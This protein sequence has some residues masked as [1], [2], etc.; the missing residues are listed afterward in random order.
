V[1]VRLLR[2]EPERDEP[3]DVAASVEGPHLLR[4]PI[5]EP[6]ALFALPLLPRELRLLADSFVRLGPDQAHVALLDAAV[7]LDREAVD[8]LEVVSLRDAEHGAVAH[9]YR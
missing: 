1:P 4:V 6:P 9:G 7:P 5:E 8:G 3:E 2:E